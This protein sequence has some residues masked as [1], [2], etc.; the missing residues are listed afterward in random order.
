LEGL[1]ALA[2]AP[3]ASI[4]LLNEQ[5]ESTL[6]TIGAFKSDGARV[7]PDEPTVTV[8]D[9][10]AFKPSVIMQFKIELNKPANNGNAI[11][12][13]EVKEIICATLRKKVV[14]AAQQPEPSVK[15][16]QLAAMT[17]DAF[18][19]SAAITIGNW[20]NQSG[21]TTQPKKL[22][23]EWLKNKRAAAG[24]PAEE[25]TAKR[26]NAESPPGG[27][28]QVASDNGGAGMAL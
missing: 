18:N 28:G 7:K 9:F 10:S 14:E 13:K 2:G 3:P 19:T 25:Q 21:P 17:K 8:N 16:T 26:T 12:S 20:W 1:L 15:V 4:M 6:R 5:G 23:A 22:K 27:G 24:A 11:C